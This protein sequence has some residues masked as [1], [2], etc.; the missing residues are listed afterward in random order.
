VDDPPAALYPDLSQPAH[1]A[2]A[3]PFRNRRHLPSDPVRQEKQ[4][5]L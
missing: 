2:L 5:A 1:A 4:S 3:S